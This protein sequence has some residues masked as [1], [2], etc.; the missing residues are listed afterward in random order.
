LIATI[1][2]WLAGRLTTVT[3][4]HRRRLRGASRQFPPATDHNGSRDLWPAFDDTVPRGAVG[5]KLLKRNLSD[6]AAMGARP[7]RRRDLP[8]ARSAGQDALA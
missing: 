6:L 7:D 2:R 4:G 3:A 8:G 1:R 5:A